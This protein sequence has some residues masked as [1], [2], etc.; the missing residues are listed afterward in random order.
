MQYVT[1]LI[2]AYYFRLSEPIDC[3]NPTDCAKCFAEQTALKKSSTGGR[4]LVAEEVGW[5]IH[6]KIKLRS[7]RGGRK[8]VNANAMLGGDFILAMATERLKRAENIQVG[9]G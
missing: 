5:A 8:D 2:H 3:I 1:Q 9:F 6:F 4:D 7:T